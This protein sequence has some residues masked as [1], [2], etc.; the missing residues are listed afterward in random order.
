MSSRDVSISFHQPWGSGSMPLHPA[1]TVWGIRSQALMLARQVNRAICP[2]SPKPG[3]HSHC[4]WYVFPLG[5]EGD[6]LCALKFFIPASLPGLAGHLFSNIWKI[7]FLLCVFGFEN[8]G[9]SFFSQLYCDGLKLFF[10]FLTNLCDNLK[11][12]LYRGF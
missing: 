12:I 1:A 5:P 3:K 7:T 10:F 8:A 6:W 2:A 9:C 4:S 11:K